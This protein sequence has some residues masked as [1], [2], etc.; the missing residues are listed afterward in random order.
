MP[1]NLR[2]SAR[3]GATG[4]LALLAAC[5]SPDPISAD[6]DGPSETDGSSGGTTTTPLTSSES[7]DPVETTGGATSSTTVEPTSDSTGPSDE[8]SADNAIDA[9]CPSDTPYCAAGT[10]VDCSGLD[11]ADVDPSTP[12]CVQG[13]CME[14]GTDDISVC[15]TTQTACIDNT[16]V[17]CT[18]D[19]QCPSGVCQADG[20]CLLESVT[21]RGLAYDYSTID[22]TPLEG[23]T[24][25]I[26]NVQDAPTA[27]ATEADG[28]YELDGLVPGTLVDL[29]PLYDQD[30]PVFVPATLSSRVSVTVTNDQPIEVDVPVVPYAWM[31]QVAFECGLF[32]TLEEAIGG[33][34]VNPYFIQRSTVFGQLVDDAGNGIATMSKAAL[35]AKVDEWANF[36][37]NLLDVDGSPTEVCFLEEDATSGT[38]V[39]TTDDV[40][41]ES[42][43]FVM[44]RVRNDTGLG[45]GQLSVSASGFDPDFTTL[46]SSG[47]IAVVDMLRNDDPIPRDFAIDVYPL[48]ETYGCVACHTAGGP[49]AAVRN[50]FE[51]DWSLGPREVWELLV[52]PGVECP[53]P[54]N[55]VRICT[56]DPE[57]SLFV[58]RPL[59]EPVGMDDVHPVDIFPSIDDPTVQVMLE[60]IAQGAQPPAA[61]R[62]VEDIYP[63][64]AKHGCVACHTGGGPPEAV[65]AGFNADWSLTPAE[66]YNLLVGPGTTCPNP[67]DPVRICTDDVLNSKLVSYPLTDPPDAPDLHPVNAF[68]SLNHPDMQLIVQW[69]AQGANFEN[70]CEHDGCALGEAL[71]P[72]CSPCATAICAADPYCC[73][74]T[75]DTQCVNQAIA[76][77]ECSC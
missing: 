1:L 37:D 6:S 55:P 43:R 41:N 67:N 3:I 52:G 26:T 36:Q 31:A 62:F 15:E 4:G 73:N 76:A 71:V 61:I 47:N 50:G 27:A 14:C 28:A 25:Q 8:C 29:Q 42:G 35:R 64:F 59:T 21:L 22:R 63:L 38:Y 32:P 46:S 44:F 69:I 54:D 65:T 77:P 24:V 7:G 57:A 16:C 23:V 13:Q 40:S 5:F 12:V 11:C 53:D 66:V 48:F 49:P 10:C 34:A 74:N 58:Q 19:D 33:A 75:W 39:G 72:G 9:A 17:A 18:E 70:T 60:W 20:E 45:Q 68:A 51:A 56:D 2:R 30:D